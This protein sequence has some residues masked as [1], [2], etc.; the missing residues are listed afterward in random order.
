[1]ETGEQQEIMPLQ[2]SE[3]DKFDLDAP[4]RTEPKNEID[5]VAVATLAIEEPTVPTLRRSKGI[6]AKTKPRWKPSLKG[7]EHHCAMMQLEE[8]GVL[9]PDAHMF[10]Q[11]NFCQLKP[12]LVAMIVTHLSLKAG[13]H[14]RSSFARFA[15]RNRWLILMSFAN[16][17]V[18]FC[19]LKKRALRRV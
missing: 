6:F 1:M 7:N 14:Q 3:D 15:I 11:T 12:D 19:G 9:Y 10:T 5:L 17:S 13:L 8:Q 18:G 2:L 16:F 4:I